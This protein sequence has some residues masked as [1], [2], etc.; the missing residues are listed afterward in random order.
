GKYF[1]IKEE[2]LTKTEIFFDKYGSFSTFS[3]RLI[4]VIRHLIS[5]PA[6]LARMN[7]TKFIIYTGVGAAI[8]AAILIVLGYF[9]GENEE[10]IHQYLKIIIAVILVLLSISAVIYYL[11]V[12]KRQKI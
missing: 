2:T 4:P 12:K 3:G 10:L 7:M 1:F 11:Y 9:I 6:G 8:W 5:I